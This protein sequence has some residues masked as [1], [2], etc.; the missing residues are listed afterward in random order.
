LLEVKRTADRS[1]PASS[2]TAR[3]RD[4]AN[5]RASNAVENNRG[6][7]LAQ[8]QPHLVGPALARNKTRIPVIIGEAHFEGVMSVN[9]VLAGHLRNNGSGLEVRQKALSELRSQPELSGELSFTDLVRVNGHIAGTVY[10]KNGTLIVDSGAAVDAMVNVA[11]AIIRGTVN[12]DIV[13]QKRVE[14]AAGAKVFGNI[15]TRSL[16]VDAGA[17]FDGDCNMLQES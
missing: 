2:K 14:L 5:Q 17:I 7:A 8:N 9:G 6:E 1:L 12:G 11:V 15:W 4:S 10:S 3:A 16:A 13:A